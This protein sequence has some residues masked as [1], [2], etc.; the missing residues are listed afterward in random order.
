MLPAFTNASRKANAL[1]AA[2]FPENAAS[3]AAISGNFCEAWNPLKRRASAIPE[4]RQ[5]L[6]L[7][8]RFDLSPNQPECF[9]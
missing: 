5:R 8:E 3:H 2:S 9:R 7:P 1:R 6:I 4:P